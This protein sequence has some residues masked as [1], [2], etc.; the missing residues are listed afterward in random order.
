MKDNLQDLVNETES[1]ITSAHAKRQKKPET[2]IASK[3][4]LPR[5]SFPMFVWLLAIIL[6]SFQ[7]TSI[8]TTVFGPAESKIEAD[9]TTILNTAAGTVRKYRDESGSL[10]PLLPN[11]A[12]RGL[13]DYDRR[14]EISFVLTATVSNVTMVLESDKLHVYRQTNEQP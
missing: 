12:I 5:L 8:V 1:A 10:P 11:P 2:K 9:L 4:Q 6:V 7:F 3:I 13:V 14:S